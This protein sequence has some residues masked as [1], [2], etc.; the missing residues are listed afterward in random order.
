MAGRAV[1]L[2]L[3]RAAPATMVILGRF[4][5]VFGLPNPIPGGR[6][7]VAMADDCTDFYD[8]LAAHY[9]LIFADWPAAI[10][11]QGDVLDRLIRSAGATGSR[12]LD[13]ACGIG[14]Q[15]LGL[16]ALGYRVTASDSSPAAVARARR[17]AAARGLAVDFRVADIRRLAEAVPAGFDV[18]LAADNALAHLIGDDDLEA[19]ASQMIAVLRP[20]GLLVISIRDYDRLLAERPVTMPPRFHDDADGRRIVHQVWDWQGE[21]H[22]ALHLYITVQD[23]ESWRVHHF[24]SRCRALRRARLADLFAAAGLIAGRWLSAEETGYYQPVFVGRRA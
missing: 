9:H 4:W 13:C 6:V 16:A 19:G 7:V 23:G 22:Y 2:S 15:T 24:P 12:L 10:A 1:G 17:E 21:E 20:G 8:A 3:A 5:G 14:T 11:A 18:V